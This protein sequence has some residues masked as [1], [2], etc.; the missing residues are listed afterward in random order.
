MQKLKKN[1]KLVVIWEFILHFSNRNQLM[2]YNLF[3]K[4]LMFKWAM[5]GSLFWSRKMFEGVHSHV[6]GLLRKSDFAPISIGSKNLDQNRKFE[7]LKSES[8]S[9]LDTWSYISKRK[10]SGPKSN[11]RANPSRENELLQTL[12]STK[13][14]DHRVLNCEPRASSVAFGLIFKDTKLKTIQVLRSSCNA[15][16]VRDSLVQIQY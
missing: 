2:L 11:F 16:N 1:R 13:K 3:E 10:L 9:D 14:R 7:L 15:I 4:Y 8:K 12:F 6:M 5:R